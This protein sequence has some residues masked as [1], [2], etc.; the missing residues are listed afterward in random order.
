M[1]RYIH[2][3]FRVGTRRT[4]CPSGSTLLLALL[5]LG[6]LVATSVAVGAIVVTRL[7]TIRLMDD[8][9]LA[10]YAAEAGVE[11]LLYRV[12]KVSDLSGIAA[13]RTLERGAQWQRT[14][15]A[16][17]DELFVT[18]PRDAVE[19]LDLFE[20]SGA[21]DTAVGIQALR[22]HVQR[23]DPNAWMEVTWVPWLASGSWST[24]VGRVLYGPSELESERRVDLLAQPFGGAAIAYRVR[25][26][27]IAGTLGVV[28]VRATADRDGQQFVAFPARVQATSVGRYGP[29]RSALRVSFPARFPLAP[30]FDYV[31]FSECDL[32]KGDEVRCP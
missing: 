5:I 1:Y 2:A 3:V 20:P 16:T 21:L 32:V 22:L 24:A 15:R 8:R 31:V 18:I 13:E 12:R 30:M 25:I 26:R 11:D 28:R 14:G 7:R 27:A 29:A 9:M 19:Q 6:G 23:P 10:T 4:P 17:V